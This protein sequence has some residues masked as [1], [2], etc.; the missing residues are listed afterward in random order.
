MLFLT[1]TVEQGPAS[2]Y[3]VYQFLP[4]LRQA[5]VPYEISPAIT[6]DEYADYFGGSKFT[7]V[8][9]LPQIYRRRR[10][11]LERFGQFD[12]IFIQK[13]F[14]PLSWPRWKFSGRLVYDLDDAVFG[15]S[16]ERIMRASTLVLA[17]NE[18]LA[19]HARRYAPHV[20]LMPTVVDT[21]RF[22]PAKAAN[23]APSRPEP[24]LGWMGSRTTLK[25]LER[26]GPLLAA[27]RGFRVKVVGSAP[28]GFACQFERWTLEGEVGQ[29]QSMDIGL[30][31]LTDGRWERGKCGL[32]VLQYWS[33]GIPVIA[34]PVGVQREMI[35][36]SGGGLLAGTLGE[37]EEKIRWLVEHPPERKMMGE[38]GRRYVAERY[39]L[40]V[41]A[42]RW[43]ELLLA[44]EQT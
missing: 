14:F 22:Q 43:V 8:R 27:P 12:L 3:R 15:R 13:E 6:G 40:K 28:P 24:T 37:W 35:E 32:K 5:G 29:L 30:A 36:Q 34:S 11:D 21:E 20:V 10:R 19:E 39:S 25:Y 4:A 18:F 16:T 42:P 9:Y 38:R 26:L 31:P 23:S 41:W 7:K 1:H 17:G 44:A 2:R 33:C